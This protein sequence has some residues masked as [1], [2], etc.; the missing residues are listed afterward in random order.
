MRL[1][2]EWGFPVGLILAWMVTTA[3]AI[4][5]MATVPPAQSVVAPKPAPQPADK[6]PRI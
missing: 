4:S 5:L 3:Y 2:R 1:F 6:V